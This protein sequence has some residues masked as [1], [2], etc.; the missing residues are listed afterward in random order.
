MTDI[1]KLKIVSKVLSIAVL[2]TIIASLL[3]HQLL[4]IAGVLSLFYVGF[5]TYTSLKTS[6]LDFAIDVLAITAIILLT[7][8][9]PTLSPVSILASAVQVPIAQGPIATPIKL[10]VSTGLVLYVVFSALEIMH[11]HKSSEIEM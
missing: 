2:V 8:Y 7:I 6:K 1:S 4:M 9:K 5:D 11:M 3:Y 10:V